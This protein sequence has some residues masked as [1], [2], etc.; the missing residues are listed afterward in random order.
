MMSNL[1][2]VVQVLKKGNGL[3]PSS[4]PKQHFS[5]TA[6]GEWL[7]E[8]YRRMEAQKMVQMSN[9]FEPDALEK[10]SKEG[11]ALLKKYIGPDAP[12]N[13]YAVSSQEIQNRWAE[14]SHRGR[15]LFPTAQ[16]EMEI[17]K[18]LE[19]EIQATRETIERTP[20]DTPARARYLDDL[21][22]LLGSRYLIREEESDLQATISFHRDAFNHKGASLG[23][24]TS[25]GERLFRWSA[26]AEDW[27]D[28]HATSASIVQLF[29]LLARPGLETS[30][31]QY[32]LGTFVGL[33]SDAA[34]AAINAG[35]DSFSALEL[36]EL[37]RGVVGGF[38][39]DMRIDVSSL[40]KVNRKLAQQ[41]VDVR[42]KLS[43]DISPEPYLA[44]GAP[45][46]SDIIEN[47]PPSPERQASQRRM[48]IQIDG[49][50]EAAESLEEVLKQIREQPG[51]Q[52]F[53]FASSRT[54]MHAIAAEGP[55]AIINVCSYR[56]DA[57]LLEQSKR[58]IVELPHLSQDTIQKKIHDLSTALPK[59]LEWMWDTVA[60][61]VL[62]E[63]GFTKPPADA[64]W[65]RVWWIPTGPLSGFPLHA[66]GYHVNGSSNTVIDR[67]MSSYTTSVK[68]I[69]LSRRRHL[70]EDTASAS[71]KA[72]LVAMKSTSEQSSLPFAAREV[73]IFETFV[74]LWYLNQSSQNATNEIY[75]QI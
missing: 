2:E 49:K 63:L 38:L 3:A 35:K 16:P 34:A 53:L 46:A 47:R 54:E 12:D 24:R 52:N 1:A 8:R 42:D 62:N 33:A 66:A 15:R 40:E 21:G 37:G 18:D 74:N 43:T 19:E 32:L 26:L 69:I 5:L 7:Q 44:E 48:Q 65:P 50:K 61:P 36:L 31:R 10:L 23:T 9:Q 70:S 25:A 51:F 20:L 41:F 73:Q 57:L 68:H 13:N 29:P 72:L 14:M 17:M 11:E 27:Q 67:V 30:D 6:L 64:R 75:Y 60:Q 59:A 55:I 45:N 39:V 56:C 4:R 22:D 28:A 58:R 71:D